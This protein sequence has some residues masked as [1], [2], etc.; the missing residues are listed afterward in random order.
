MSNMNT[1]NDEVL[2]NAVGGYNTTDPNGAHW[3]ATG[4][5][6]GT[7]F[8]MQGMRWY[9]IQNG[10]TLGNIARTFG[11]T[12]EQLQKNNPKTITNPGMIYAG[13]AIVIRRA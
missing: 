9:R 13:D 4:Y 2:E 1:L 8:V 5:K 7:T 12:V 3:Q 11:T 10:D 6:M